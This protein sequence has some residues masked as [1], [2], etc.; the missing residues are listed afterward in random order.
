MLLSSSTAPRRKYCGIVYAEIGRY[1]CGQ[2]RRA[3]K[4]W[5][6][7]KGTHASTS[8]PLVLKRAG[9]REKAAM[10]VARIRATLIHLGRST[11]ETGKLSNT[12]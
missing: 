6:E 10:E 9:S 12:E 2:D 3:W 11:W 8:P 7:G 5:Q 4:L 1:G